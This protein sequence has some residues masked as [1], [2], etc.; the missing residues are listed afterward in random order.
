LGANANWNRAIQ[1]ATSQWVVLLHH[2]DELLPENLAALDR[3]RAEF[4]SLGLT[5]VSPQAALA[6]DSLNRDQVALTSGFAKF[7]AGRGQRVI[8]LSLVDALNSIFPNPVSLWIQRT[9][10]LES[11]GLDARWGILSDSVW[12]A[13]LARTRQTGIYPLTLAVS[14]KSGGAASLSPLAAR[15][16]L[17]S[18]YRRTFAITQALGY[19]INCAQRVARRNLVFAK[20]ALL[21]Q[22][23]KGQIESDGDVVAEVCAELKI[24][25]RVL[26]QPWLTWFQV[27]KVLA[28]TKLR[29][30]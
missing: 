28:W 9:R 30:R 8:Q 2:D 16:V 7:I 26:R 12:F 21:S 1:L 19:S 27:R 13:N 4:D 3:H 14:H 10:A 15:S 6:T 11:G 24:P 17:L 18:Y 22:G 20:L 23:A 5:A 25:L 29:W